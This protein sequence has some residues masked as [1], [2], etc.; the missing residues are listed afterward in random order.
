MALNDILEKIKKETEAK[1]NKIQEE[2][3]A[4]IKELEADSDKKIAIEKEKI[5]SRARK[6]AGKKNKQAQI[7][8]SLETKK[9]ILAQRQSIIDQVWQLVLEDLSHLDNQQYSELINDLLIK[10]P[11]EKGKIMAAR[12]REE[13]TENIIKKNNR[14]YLL[15]DE[16]LNVSGGFIYSSDKIEINATFEELIKEMKEKNNV[17]LIKILFN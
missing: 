15:A 6:Q 4:K 17:D 3:R 9:L 5:L 10:C 11:K 7:K 2:T 8:I 1:I 13:I 14:D 12:G 16:S